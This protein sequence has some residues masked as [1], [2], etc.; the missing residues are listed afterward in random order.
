MASN[1]AKSTISNLKSRALGM[2]NA[3]SGNNNTAILGA[4]I[5]EAI[6][7]FLFA[8]VVIV[9]QGTPIFVAFSLIGIALIVGSL[10]GSHLNPA[11]TIGAWLTRK[12]SGMRALAYIIAQF[13]GAMLAFAVLSY[14]IKGSDQ[15]AADAASYGQVAPE[16][17]KALAI[18]AGKEWYLV[19]A[20]I[21]GA[22]IF[23]LAFA[24]ALSV[25][26]DRIVA[27][28]GLGFGLLVA[29][30]I[31]GTAAGYVNGTAIFNPAV[32]SSL[33]ALKWEAWSIVIYAIAPVVGAVVG[34]FVANTLRKNS[35]GG[36]DK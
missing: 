8:A 24:T 36:S 29:L 7:T 31:A 34:F 6:G 12:V 22:F 19:F 25:K 28:T 2:S 32:A 9:T 33:S 13:A 18:S 1:K 16:L 30:V 23:G 4:I 17:Y 3:K 5:A 11:I 26:R 27:A 21:M 10:S 35:D 20:E 14:F 15:P